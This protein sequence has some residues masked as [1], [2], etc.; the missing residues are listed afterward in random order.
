MEGRRALLSDVSPAAVH[1]A[2]NYTTPCDPEAFADALAVVEETMKPTIAWLYR[3]VGTDQIVEYTTWSDVHLLRFL[4]QPDPV[5]GC[6]AERTSH[7]R[8]PADL[9]PLRH[10]SHRKADL[11]WIGEEPD[12]EPHFAWINVE[13]IPT[14]RPVKNWP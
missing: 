6:R 9:S 1:I 7:P 14:H 12:P 5:L 10:R 13:S 3:P 2:R 11:Q 4:P 8:K